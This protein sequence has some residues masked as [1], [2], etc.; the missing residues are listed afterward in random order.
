VAAW[1]TTWRR[2]L[3]PLHDELAEDAESAAAARPITQRL[4]RL[5]RR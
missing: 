4:G 2:L 3:A 5:G 1:R